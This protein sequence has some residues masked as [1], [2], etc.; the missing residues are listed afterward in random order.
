MS[1]LKEIPSDSYRVRPIHTHKTQHYECEFGAG[2]NDTEVFI[3]LAEENPDVHS[4]GFDPDTDTT[5]PDGTYQQILYA[6]LNHMFYGG[7]T[8]WN[9]GRELIKPSLEQ[10]YV[11]NAAQRTYGEKIKPGSVNIS[12]VSSAEVIIDDGV[13][14]LIVSSSQENVG[15][16]F[17]DMGIA[18]IAAGTGNEVDT[19]GLNLSNGSILDVEFKATHTIYEHTVICTMDVG[20]MAFTFN[21]SIAE[22]AASGELIADAI[23]SGSLTPYMTT[24]GLYNNENQLVAVAKFPRPIK[25]APES[26]QTFIIRFDA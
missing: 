22:E 5:N 4:W 26:Q 11:I 17:Y 20:D 8:M 7:P 2:G 19:D 21:P 24:V 3:D 25:R 10:L 12:S 14:N 18:V 6:S 9:G 23:S 13:G 1:I 16:I 15:H